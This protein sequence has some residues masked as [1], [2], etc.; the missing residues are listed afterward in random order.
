MRLSALVLTLIL[1]SP[2]A[3]QT[4]SGRGASR[5]ATRRWEPIVGLH[6]DSAGS[7]SAV[8]GIGRV[9]RRRPVRPDYSEPDLLFAAVE[10]GRD[11]GRLSVGLGTI[12]GHEAA[13]LLTLRGSLLRQ[14]RHASRNWV[15]VEGSASVFLILGLRVGAFYALKTDGGSGR[16]MLTVD[17]A[18]GF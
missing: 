11:N 4:S 16:S 7:W 17:W 12:R 10:P 18:M 13:S 8:G 2:L 5:D 9:L 1:A 6:V 14:W 3:A 15:G